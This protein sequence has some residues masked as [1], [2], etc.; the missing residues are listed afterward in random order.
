M[1]LRALLRDR[2]PDVLHTH[3]A[4]AGATGRIA[5]LARRACAAAV[6]SC[7]RSTA[8]CSRGYF[9][10][11]RE[12]VVPPDRAGAR[13]AHRRARS[14]SASRCETTSSRFGVAPPEKF[15]VIPYGFDLD[16]RVGAAAASRA[17][18]RAELGV[19][20]DAFVIGWAG[21]L[22]AIKR[23]LDLVRAAQLVRRQRARARR[24]RR[25]AR[26]RRARSPREL[27]VAD[28]VRLLGYVDDL[29]SLVRARSTRSCSRRR[30]RAHRSSR[31]RRSRPACRSSRPT[32]AA[33]ARSS[34]TARPASLAPVGD[35][36]ALAARLRRLRDDP[37]LR[38]RARRRPGAT[39]MRERFSVERMVD[40]VDALYAEILAR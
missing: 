2:R 17:T 26:R 8:T 11:R 14:R 10:P 37:A 20:D 30:T 34:T 40:D 35:V 21:R 5:A 32:P 16:A 22:T 6:R 24:R 29:G 1:T 23:P 18:A 25:A 12:R 36:D 19:G 28:R 13:P 27:G 33:R 31:S 39:R 3:T 4:K 15:A 38:A 9:D 7:T